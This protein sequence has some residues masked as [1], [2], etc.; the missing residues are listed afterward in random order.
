[1]HNNG[2]TTY[3][4]KMSKLEFPYNLTVKELVESE[5][6]ARNHWERVKEWAIVHGDIETQREAE[7]IIR[8]TAQMNY[9]NIKLVQARDKKIKEIENLKGAY[10]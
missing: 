3:G 6:K 10:I 1:M 5:R 2:S 7:D 9:E 8:A 4:F